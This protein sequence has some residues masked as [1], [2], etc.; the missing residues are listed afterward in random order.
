VLGES[1]D[2][3]DINVERSYHEDF[4]VDEKRRRSAA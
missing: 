4:T 3:W 1:H 2:L